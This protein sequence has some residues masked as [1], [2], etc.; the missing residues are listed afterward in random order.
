VEK[1]PGFC[2]TAASGGG[3]TLNQ[4]AYIVG[5]TNFITLFF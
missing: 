1:F 2:W 5:T 4:M 3:M